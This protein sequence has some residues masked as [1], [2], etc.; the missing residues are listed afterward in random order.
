MSC[1]ARHIATPN[2][3]LKKFI[4][5]SA[6]LPLNS[7]CLEYT[8]DKFYSGNP[9]KLAI[10]RIN[11]SDNTQMQQ[12][13]VKRNIDIIN[14]QAADGKKIKDISTYWGEN[15]VNFHHDM[16]SSET[17]NVK[18]RDMSDW[19]CNYGANAENYYSYFLALFVLNGILFENFLKSQE[20]TFNSI[21][22]E[23][24][25]RKVKENF[26]FSPIIIRFIDS[27]QEDDPKWW[28]YPKSVSN[29]IDKKII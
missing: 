2:Y 14:L 4:E 17:P 13:N 11:I 27:T 1:I 6:N 19:V 9:D 29:I 20:D 18:Y 3:E 26:G 15:L 21:I 8:N 7:I 28:S 12:K 22:V 16:L 5:C 24:A 23:P 10:G 25:F